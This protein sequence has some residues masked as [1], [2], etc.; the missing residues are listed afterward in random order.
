MFADYVVLIDENRNMLEG[1]IKR[2]R[3][4]QETNGLK[5]NRTK[6]NF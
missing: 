2:W 5:I 6:I 4:V 3:G 1:K